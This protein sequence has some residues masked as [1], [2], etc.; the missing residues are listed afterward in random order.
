MAIERVDRPA[1][2]GTGEVSEEAVHH[3]LQVEPLFQDGSRRTG[4]RGGPQ[5]CSVFLTPGGMTGHCPG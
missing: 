2:G 5:G 4:S 1:V 3:L